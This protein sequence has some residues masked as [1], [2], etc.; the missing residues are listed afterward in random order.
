MESSYGISFIKAS[1][2]SSSSYDLRILKS[3]FELDFEKDRMMMELQSQG[4][5]ID[6]IKSC[7]KKMPIDSHIIEAIKSAKSSGYEQWSVHLDGLSF[8]FLVESWV[9]FVWF[10]FADVI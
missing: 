6:D 8:F 10:K 1:K 4:R 7:L 3:K 2:I 5:S 9:L